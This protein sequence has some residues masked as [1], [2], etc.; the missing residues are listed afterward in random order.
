[1][2]TKN[3]P[4]PSLKKFIEPLDIKQALVGLEIGNSDD[5]VIRYF[6]F[7]TKQIPTSAAYFIHVIQKEELISAYYKKETFPIAD[8]PDID[9][10]FIREM[11]EKINGLFSQKKNLY[12]EYEV[13]DGNPLEEILAT[14]KSLNIDLLVIGQKS[15][16]GNHTILA[17]NLARKTS[18]TALIIPEQA[19][20]EISN[21]LVPIDFSENSARAL[22]A[23]IG[24]HKQLKNPAK[25]TCLNVYTIPSLKHFKFS[26]GWI[27]TQKTV[28][29]NIRDGFD[30]FLETFAGDYK[31]NIEIE[32]VE[33][34]QPGIANY[35]MDF[36]NSHKCDFLCLGA[37]G[38]SNVHL[39]LM[40]SVAEEILDINQSIP[41]MIIK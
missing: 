3:N 11:E 41:T 12:V 20:L 17:K 38:H 35:I 37:K 14:A 18:A 8:K 28:A 1:M 34:T 27:Q 7:F 31:N 16:K 39:L 24:I 25:I 23:A 13:K 33:R 2:S 40:G 4:K 19:P 21:I 26:S 22:Q 30:A 5:Q 10:T 15:S 29:S 6:D 32:L 36:A 9:E